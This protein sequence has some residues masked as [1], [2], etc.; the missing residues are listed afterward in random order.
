M[1]LS[2]RLARAWSGFAPVCVPPRNAAV[3]LNERLAASAANIAAMASSSYVFRGGTAIMVSVRLQY[4]DR[5]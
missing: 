3:D 5:G 4:H 1:K 2:R